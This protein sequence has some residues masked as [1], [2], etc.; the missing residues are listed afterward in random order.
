MPGIS[1]T[2]SFRMNNRPIAFLDSGVGG[3]GYLEWVRSRLDT[4]RYIYISDSANFPY[5]EKPAE[6]VLRAVTGTVEAVLR[7]LDPKVIVIACNTASVVALGELRRRFSLPFVGVVPAVKPAAL[8]SR[9]R[10]IGL[11]ATN[12]TVQDAYT[13]DLIDKF[14]EDC[15]MIFFQGADTVRY[16][17]EK[18]WKESP[19]EK[20][21]YLTELAENFSA[22]D[23][24]T[25]VLGCTHF[26]YLA[27]E[28]KSL[29]RPRIDVIDS[30]EGVGRQVIRI[31]QE[32]GLECGE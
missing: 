13:R 16:I 25:L 1:S 29:L 21:T 6:D 24:D 11:F 7:R 3:L 4:E 27:D 10:K 19:L 17:E 14:A 5:G 2:P 26:V 12:R 31:I 23:I 8:A 18:F 32:N 22:R 30:R 28:L 15:S 9:F 20:E